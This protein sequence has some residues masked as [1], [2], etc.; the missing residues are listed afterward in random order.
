ME[1]NG[2]IVLS[3]LI[4]GSQYGSGDMLASGESP[5]SNF[6]PSQ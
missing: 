2:I 1:E 5:I 6:C 4:G 3:G